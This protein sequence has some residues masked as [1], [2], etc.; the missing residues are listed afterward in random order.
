[1]IIFTGVA[2]SGKSVQGRML[3]DERALP[4]VATGE[5]LRML[6][7]GDKRK[8]MLA[9]KLLNDTE[10]ISLIRKIFTVVD[11]NQE[12]VLDGFPRTVAQ[13]DWLLSQVKHGQLEVTAVIHLTASQE[14][15]MK[16]LLSRGRPDD[17]KEAIA[18]RFNEYEQQILPILEHFKSAGVPV[19]DISGEQGIEKVHADISK[20]LDQLAGKTSKG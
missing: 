14:G 13:A 5:F 18:A 12:F 10:I 4:W 7:S 17:T 20:S 6:I 3:A 8:D 1:M 9:G 2:G 19:F 11:T 16:R 15:V